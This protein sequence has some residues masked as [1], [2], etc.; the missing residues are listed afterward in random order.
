MVMNLPGHSII[1]NCTIRHAVLAEFREELFMEELKN[2]VIEKTAKT[3]RIELIHASGEI[4]FTG[5]SLPEN[6]TRI[7]EPVLSWVNDY[8]IQPKPV[9]NLRL[10]LEYYNTSSMLWISKII[11]SLSR[12]NNPDY[13]LMVHVYIPLEEYDDMRESADIKESFNP[14]TDILQNS[15][16]EVS[17]KLYATDESSRVIRDAVVL[18]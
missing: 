8:I 9:T 15:I 3:P 18:F 14:L 6:A 16:P 12:I 5:K 1:L 10:N 4:S 7:Y 13:R 11:K 17:M 2:L